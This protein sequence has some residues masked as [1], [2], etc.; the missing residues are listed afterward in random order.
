MSSPS[1]SN[2]PVGILPISLPGIKAWKAVAE[3]PNLQSS[4]YLLWSQYTTFDL[5]L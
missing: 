1:V 5:S 2:V 4:G 3:P